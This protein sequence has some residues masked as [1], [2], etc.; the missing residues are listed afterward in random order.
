VLSSQVRAD[1]V[2]SHAR[3]VEAD[4]WH[5]LV[6]PDNQNLWG[7]PFVAMAM[8][9]AATT[10]LELTTGAT[11][12]ATRHPAVMA[13]A[14]A[15]VSTASKGRASLGIARG[16]SALAHIG[17]APVSMQQFED[18]VSLV[19]RY[20]HGESVVFDEIDQWRTSRSISE[21]A[22]A[23]APTASRLHWL[24]PGAPSVPVTVYASGPR[25]IAVAARHAERIMFGL[26]A[27]K[28]RLAWGIDLARQS[29]ELIGRDPT[30]LR[31]GAGM[32]VGVANDIERARALVAN[33]VASS[34]RFSALHGYVASP[35]PD[36]YR[37]VYESVVRSYD[38][39][40]HGAMG[41]QI[42]ML[43]PEFIDAFAVVGTAERCVERL[44]DLQEAGIDDILIAP[45]RNDVDPSD[46]ADSYDALVAEVLPAL[47]DDHL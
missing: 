36:A 13:S 15:S 31:L 5:G 46:K 29:C 41:H 38:M 44:R 26:G 27:D 2:A 39:T 28:E 17:A 37:R 24:P 18:Y 47:C 4:G 1:Q 9:A 3:Q 42:E 21:L 35:V 11:N 32:S 14:I 43:T 23:S 19:S 34:A 40:K 7:D 25:A 30:E 45:P 16:D 6:I 20:L 22:L 8:A 10:R 33:T 12:P